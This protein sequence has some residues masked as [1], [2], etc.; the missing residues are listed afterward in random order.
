MSCEPWNN[1]MYNCVEVLLLYVCRTVY[2]LNYIYISFKYVIL[3][4]FVGFQAFTRIDLFNAVHE[5]LR[6]VLEYGE[7]GIPYIRFV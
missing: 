1:Y 5:V 6:I 7:T 4:L 3:W 2:V